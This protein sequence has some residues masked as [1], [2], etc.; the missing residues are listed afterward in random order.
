MNSYL[1][2]IFALSL[3]CWTIIIFLPLPSH[4]YVSLVPEGCRGQVAN[5]NG[6]GADGC[7]LSQ[8]EQLIINAATLLLGVTGSITL[9]MFV[10]AGILLMISGGDS[11][12]VKKAT[13]LLKNT[14]IGLVVIMFAGLIVKYYIARITNVPA[15]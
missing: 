14:F 4:A 10:Y 5:V 13:D 1:K 6:Q 2:F 9:A 15:A 11:A 3:I 12:K 7:G 8:V